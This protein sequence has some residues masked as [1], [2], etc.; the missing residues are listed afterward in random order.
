M[1][2]S[3]WLMLTTSIALAWASTFWLFCVLRFIIG[4]CVAGLYVVPFVLGKWYQVYTLCHL[5]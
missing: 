5:Y 1:Y 4:M 3:T 2:L